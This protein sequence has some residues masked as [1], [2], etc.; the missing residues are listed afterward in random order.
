VHLG[1]AAL[2]Q[3][4]AA[5]LTLDKRAYTTRPGIYGKTPPAERVS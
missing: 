5:A 4:R 2:A 1:P 3:A